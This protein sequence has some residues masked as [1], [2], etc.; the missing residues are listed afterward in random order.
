MK[1]RKQMVIINNRQGKCSKGRRVVY[2]TYALR[3]SWYMCL[4]FCCCEPSPLPEAD[5]L[6]R[7]FV[8][9]PLISPCRPGAKTK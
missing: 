1:G 3:R 9:Y 5:R 6:R 8:D 2:Q 4:G 7:V